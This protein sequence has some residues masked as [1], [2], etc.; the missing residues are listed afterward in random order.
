MK[1]ARYY[2]ESFFTGHEEGA[3]ASARVVLPIIHEL[4]RPRSVIDV[5]CGVGNWLKVWKDELNVQDILE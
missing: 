4:F 1:E 3:L 5:G 2:K